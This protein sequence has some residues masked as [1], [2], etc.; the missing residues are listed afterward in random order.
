M[1]LTPDKIWQSGLLERI[2]K[3][4]ENNSRYYLWKEWYELI[5]RLPTDEELL[6]RLDEID[7]NG[8]PPEFMKVY[9]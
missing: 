4:R 8:L 5:W 6:R 7:Y 1:K 2:N 9:K 3:Q